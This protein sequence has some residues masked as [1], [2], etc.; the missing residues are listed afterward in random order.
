MAGVHSC[1]M[2]RV[3]DGLV[4]AVWVTGA[5]LAHSAIVSYRL[6]LRHAMPYSA[7]LVSPALW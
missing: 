6:Q 3:G 2:G 4:T 7:T 5:K 1:G